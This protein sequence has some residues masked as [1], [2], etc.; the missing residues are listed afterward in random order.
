MGRSNQHLKNFSL[1]GLIYG[2]LL[3]FLLTTN[4]KNLSVI[5]LI[6]PFV[7]LFI[8]LFFTWLLIV[9]ALGGKRSVLR[10]RRRQYIVAALLAAGPTLMLLLDSVDQLTLKDGLLIV[11]FGIFALFYASKINFQKS[12]L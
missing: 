4:P 8:A 10:S 3:V 2:G 11:V 7:L 6:V 12:N 9:R 1:I 5:W